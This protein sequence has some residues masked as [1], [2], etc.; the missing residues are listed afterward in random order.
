MVFYPTRYGNWSFEI[1]TPAI[2]FMKKIILLIFI[3]SFA[4]VTFFPSC[5]KEISCEGCKDGNKPPIAVA[6]PDQVIT[7]PTDSLSLDGSASSD[8]DGKIS[9]WL[10]KKIS[11]PASYNIN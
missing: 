6:G 7:L 10:W 11:G 2:F 9:E 1:F 5:Q 3:L 4:G 8:P